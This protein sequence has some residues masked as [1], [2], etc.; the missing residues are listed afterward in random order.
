MFSEKEKTRIREI[1][2]NIVERI[3]N[4]HIG[5]FRGMD[6]PLF[7][8]SEQYPGVWLE[9]VWDSVLYAQ[10]VP[11]KTDIAVNTICLFID[12]QKKDGQLPCYVWNPDKIDCSSAELIGYSHIQECVSFAQL[13]LEVYEMTGDR[14]LLEKA[15]MSITKWVSWLKSNRMTLKCGLIEMFVGYDTGHDNSGRLEGISCSGLYSE[16]GV[17]MNASVL[18]EDDI[19]PIIAVD[20]NANYYATLIALAKMADLLKLDDDAR[21]WKSEAQQVKE[22]LFEMCFDKEKDKEL[23]R[24]IYE[25][26]IKNPEEF[27]TEYPFPSM[28]LSDQSFKKHTDYNCWGYF[29]QGLIALRCIRWM[30]YYGMSADF[31]IVCEKW[32]KAWSR[33]YDE[34]KLGQEL[35]PITGKPSVSSEW[36]SSSMLFYWYAAKRLHIYIP[37]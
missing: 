3:E 13:C 22:K 23:I 25:M 12:R 21:K 6:K 11:S 24:K 4:D 32:L 10:L 28:A 34:F 20:M 17:A 14:L 19:V 29:S 37:E 15:W 18:P 16:N 31:D 8:I 33:C 2:K 1:C 35:D 27:W 36:Y 30:D 9:H 7:L 26:H 5:C